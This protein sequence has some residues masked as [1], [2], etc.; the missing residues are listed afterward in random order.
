LAQRCACGGSAGLD[1]ECESCREERL[2]LKRFIQPKLAVHPIGDPYEVEADRVAEQ[3][4]AGSA[5]AVDAD[6][7]SLAPPPP[8]I[9]PVVQRAEETT[10]SEEDEKRDDDEVRDGEVQRASAAGAD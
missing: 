2:S 3:I 6:V 8:S 1:G 5:H 7:P 9:T 10:S 4:T